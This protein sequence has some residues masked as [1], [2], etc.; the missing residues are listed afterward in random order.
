MEFR[1]LS[2]IKAEN[3][4]GTLQMMNRNTMDSKFLLGA[5]FYIQNGSRLGKEGVRNKKMKEAFTHQVILGIKNLI[6]AQLNCSS[7]F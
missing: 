6:I 1:C 2:Q 5:T 3:L 7:A 4:R